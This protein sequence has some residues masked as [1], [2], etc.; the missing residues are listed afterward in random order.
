MP[1]PDRQ[2]VSLLERIA[3]HDEAAMAEFYRTFARQVYAFALRQAGD[4]GDAE[5]AVVE[6]MHEVWRVA[7]RFAGGSLVRTW[8]FSIARHKLVD[9]ARLLGGGA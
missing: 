1:D 3:R 2:A 8:L 5:D 9:Q 7:G 4:P 6:T